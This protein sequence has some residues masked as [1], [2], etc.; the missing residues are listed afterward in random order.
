MKNVWKEQEIMYF[1]LFLG[2]QE[3]I[4][5]PS[6]IWRGKGLLDISPCKDMKEVGADISW[7]HELWPP[8]INERAVQYPKRKILEKIE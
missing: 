6:R 2:V 8:F 1:N 5:S 7:C 4:K 3:L